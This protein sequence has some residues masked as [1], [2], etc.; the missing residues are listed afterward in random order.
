MPTNNL[1]DPKQILNTSR[2]FLMAAQRCA[3][4]RDNPAANSVSFL[5]APAVVNAAFSCELSIKAILSYYKISF[6]RGNS[7][8]KI[9]CLFSHLPNVLQAKIKMTVNTPDFCS[10]LQMISNSFV[11]WRY[12]FEQDSASIPLT[13]LMLLAQA[14]YQEAETLIDKSSIAHKQ[15]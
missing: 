11:E 12:L 6:P 2:S 4:K 10:N 13:F 8:H 1:H 3:E 9:G 7:G 15:F 5:V 14:L